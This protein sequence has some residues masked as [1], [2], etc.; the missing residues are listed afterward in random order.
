MQPAMFASF[1]GRLVTWLFISVLCVGLA[2]CGGGSGGGD[3]A[4]AVKSSSPGLFL[5]VGNIG[6]RSG[7]DGTGAAARFRFPHGIAIDVVGNLYVAD[8]SNSTIR[9]I[10]PAGV[11]TTLAGT[12]G[13]TGSADGNGA[14]AKF[15]YPRGIA[16]DSASNLYVADT[17]NHTIRKITSAG[18]VT[19][20][21][22]SARMIGRADGNGDVARFS[23][24]T[25]IAVDEGGNVYV[26][27]TGNYTIRKI[28]PAGVVT[29]L[30]GTAGLPICITRGC[31]STDRDGFGATARFYNPHDIAIDTAG[32]LYV[33]DGGMIRKVSPAGM[34]TTLT[35]PE[36]AGDI[37]GGLGIATDPAGNL[38]VTDV[39]IR[40]IASAGV[41]TILAGGM[42]GSADGSGTAAQFAYPSGIV[43]DAAG[44]LYVSD[45][46]NHTIRKVTP[47]GAVTTLA[48]TAGMTEYDSDLPGSADGGG[49]AARFNTPTGIAA[50]AAGNVYVADSGN[51]TIRKIMP[52][53][54]VTTFAGAAGVMGRTDGNG[55]AARFDS[56]IGIVTDTVGNMYVAGAGNNTIRKITSAGEVTTLAAPTGIGIL[57]GGIAIDAGSNLYVSDLLSIHKITSAGVATTLAGGMIGSADGSGAAAQFNYPHDIASDAAGNLY[58]ADTYNH[59]IR[60]IT[61]AGLVTT[62]AGTAGVAGSVDG[63][64]AAARFNNP[65]GIAV[66]AV[67]NVYV[68]DTENSTIRKITPTGNVSTVAGIAMQFGI[69]P[70]ELPGSLN[71]PQ[72]ITMLN[73]NTLVLTCGNSVLKLILP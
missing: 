40:K 20:L 1:V 52:G 7:G 60:K 30:A 49:A 38:Y 9:K 41:V 32:N 54:I 31:G 22:G 45:T 64:G 51:S 5:V 24:P 44:N 29:T 33:A 8:S 59:T 65:K 34:V 12:P 73:A 47:A 48:G 37:S 16:A 68:A 66:D 53:G 23:G 19:T 13:V 26:A 63:T 46:N 50:D 36:G 58:V 11:V 61:P 39:A 28:T 57:T 6:G 14:A 70:G 69:Q 21:A 27:D 10:T 67:G 35:M 42:K 72:K 3:A 17:H 2:A 43:A 25:G 71:R 15:N 18:V 4:S 55:A 56:L 62:L